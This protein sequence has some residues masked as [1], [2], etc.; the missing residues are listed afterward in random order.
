MSTSDEQ[1]F[2]LC[3]VCI[4]SC[5]ASVMMIITYTIFTVILCEQYKR[6]TFRIKLSLALINPQHVVLI[7][8]HYMFEG[9]QGWNHNGTSV[10][11]GYLGVS[12][13]NTMFHEY[14]TVQMILIIVL[15]GYCQIFT[16]NNTKLSI[17]L[18]QKYRWI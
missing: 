9:Y 7:P 4:Y 10:C 2:S 11:R 16:G 6:L 1:M 13:N 5:N 17:T 15:T 3:S 18:F 14:R 12:G 8:Y